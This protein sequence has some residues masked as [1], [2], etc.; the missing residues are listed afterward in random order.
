[1]PTAQMTTTTREPELPDADFAF[2]I[3][4]HKG[5]GQA[6]RFFTATAEFIKACEAL[7]RELAKTIDLNIEP[8]MMLEDVEA[9]SLKTFSALY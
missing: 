8:I 3:D 6:S 4:F 9:G 1:M 7:D 2:C 5:R